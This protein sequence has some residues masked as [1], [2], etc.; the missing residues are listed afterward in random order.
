MLHK[1][2]KAILIVILLVAPWFIPAIIFTIKNLSFKNNANFSSQNLQKTILKV[3]NK[4]NL[5]KSNIF[6]YNDLANI[7][8]K[9]S[10]WFKNSNWK[11]IFL[12]EPE[13]IQEIVKKYLYFENKHFVYNSNGGP[14]KNLST[15]FSNQYQKSQ[16]KNF[17]F[18]E[19]KLNSF[20]NRFN[21]LFAN[22]FLIIDNFEDYERIFKTFADKQTFA[23]QNLQKDFFNNTL[24]L[25]YI[26]Q[27]KSSVVPIFNK[28]SLETDL[29]PTD[30]IN[31]KNQ[32]RILSID[33][34]FSNYFEEND[35]ASQ[36]AQQ[37]FQIFY[38][39]VPKNSYNKSNPLSSI[40]ISKIEDLVLYNSLDKKSVE[41][42]NFLDFID[43]KTLM[44]SKNNLKKTR[45][46]A[47][48][49]G[50]N[51]PS[52]NEN[53]FFSRFNEVKDLINNKNLLKNKDWEIAFHLSNLFIP[54]NSQDKTYK[55][56]NF[57][58]QKQQVN[59]IFQDEIIYWEF[60]KN[61]KKIIIYTINYKD[62]FPKIGKESEKFN[63]DNLLRFEKIDIGD[64]DVQEI[65]VKKLNSIL[66]FNNLYNK[67]MG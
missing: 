65:H 19:L 17:N 7:D 31:Y 46:Y 58:L 16:D 49:T 54:I 35:A 48:L 59:E 67:I 42:N 55:F 28:T 27:D 14:T 11:T 3:E 45:I 6:S 34:K 57:I 30:L 40:K 52:L 53:Q 26:K 51:T 63:F 25:V 37:N 2:N 47:S 61:F 18:K 41:F 50:E 66:D 43:K 15:F 1:K 64:I 29:S 21:D 56:N 60:D 4:D 8:S 10:P 13:K 44:L 62:I 9:N 20:S 32:N 36:K 39:P 5:I 23:T 24:L 12:Q 22:N 33:Q 38:K